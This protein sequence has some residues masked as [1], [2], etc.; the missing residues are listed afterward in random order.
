M[1]VPPPYTPLPLLAGIKE[2]TDHFLEAG[3]NTSR[4]KPLILLLWLPELALSWRK[5][6]LPLTDKLYTVA[7]DQ[8]G[9]GRTTG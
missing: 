7:Y 1:T 3:Y 2:L 9:Y 5:V 6:M 4:R 8:R